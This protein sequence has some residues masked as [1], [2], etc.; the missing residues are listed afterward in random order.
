MAGSLP[1]HTPVILGD[2][3]T[4]LDH[5]NV[6]ILVNAILHTSSQRQ[7]PQAHDH[8][9]VQRMVKDR[10]GI[11]GARWGVATAEAILKL[12]ALQANGD[13][14][15]YWTYHR[16]RERERNHGSSYTLAA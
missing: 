10:M 8:P 6:R 7:L 15:E 1:G 12:R 3:I 9:K 2:T 14:D 11:S 16:H 5:R 4:G 13:F